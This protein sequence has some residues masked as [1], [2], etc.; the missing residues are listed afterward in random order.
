MGRRGNRG[1]RGRDF[2]D[3]RPAQVFEAV[4]AGLLARYG[5]TRGESIVRGFDRFL[6]ARPKFRAVLESPG[7]AHQFAF[8]GV[9]EDIIE[10][11]RG[12]GHL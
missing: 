5:P 2:D 9:L 4:N 11:V 8:K 3:R 1:Q 7:V 12:E 6:E 10:H